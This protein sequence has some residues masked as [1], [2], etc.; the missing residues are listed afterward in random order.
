MKAGVC[1]LEGC[2]CTLDGLCIV[3]SIGLG[4][5]D[6]TAEATRASVET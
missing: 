6:E 2:V 3:A 4:P 1:S 5:K